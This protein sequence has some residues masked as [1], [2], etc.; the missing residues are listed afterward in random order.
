VLAAS[1]TELRFLIPAW[2][3]IVL[4][5]V[6]TV[7][8]VFGGRWPRVFDVLSM[9]VLGCMVGLVASIWVPLH[10]AI[11]IC[12][13]GIVVG[14]LTAFF[15][16]VV[17]A[18]LTGIVLAAVFSVLAALAVGREGFAS[19]LVVDFSPKSYSMRIAGPNLANDP[20]LA[21]GLVG[22]L[23]GVAIAI[24]RFDFSDRLATSAQG[25]AVIIVGATQRINQL[26]GEDHVPLSQTFPLTLAAAWLCLLAVGLACQA[27]MG[28]WAAMREAAAEF[29]GED[30]D[31]REV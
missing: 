14:G 24:M 21:A 28:E 13:G 12:V 17:H 20:V 29:P 26:R 10:P 27:A 30:E 22:L 5:L 23:A 25:A 6:G 7:Y 4:A 1:T 2:G 19:Y 8:L 16:S 15:R 11:V 9:T 3:D 31:M 18:V